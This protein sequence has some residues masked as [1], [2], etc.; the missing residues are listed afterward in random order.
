M[1]TN[2]DVVLLEKDC[3]DGLTAKDVIAL[4]AMIKEPFYPIEIFSRIYETSAMGFIN[5]EAA[6]SL[7]YE[8]DGLSLYVASIID[9]MGMENKNH[10]YKFRGLTIFLDRNLPE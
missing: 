2:K 8:Y 1:I 10:L 4:S 6:E 3:T 9:D 5:A 7:N